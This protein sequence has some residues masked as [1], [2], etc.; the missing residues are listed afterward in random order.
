[1]EDQS[2][3][4]STSRELLDARFGPVMLVACA[5]VAQPQQSCLLE[6]VKADMLASR[7]HT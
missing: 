6:E 7:C 4:S 2:Y 3:K 5:A 1:M